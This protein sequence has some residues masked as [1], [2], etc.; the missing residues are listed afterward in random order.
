MILE[1]R[2]GKEVFEFTTL[3]RGR[4]QAYLGNVLPKDVQE[5]MAAAFPET[6]DAYEDLTQAYRD[7]WQKYHLMMSFK[8][9]K[10]LD[11]LPYLHAFSDETGRIFGRI[12]EKESRIEIGL[13]TDEREHYDIVEMLR[14]GRALLYR[15]AY[16]LHRTSIEYAKTHFGGDYLLA[17]STICQALSMM[18]ESSSVNPMFYP[19]R[20]LMQMLIASAVGKTDPKKRGSF[21]YWIADAQNHAAN[22]YIYVSIVER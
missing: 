10:I 20:V 8:V 7:Y 22:S 5:A 12:D 17:F 19:D 4:M 1:T 3:M 15:F 13:E 16:V 18:P 9:E 14:E 6:K 2:D 21:E 11:P